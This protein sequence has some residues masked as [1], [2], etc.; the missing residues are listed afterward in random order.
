MNKKFT[1]HNSGERKAFV[2]TIYHFFAL[3]IPL[4]ALLPLL[5]HAGLPNTA[6]GPAHLMRQ[7]ELNEA[8]QQ[9]TFYPRW[10]TDL[11]LGHGMP[12]FSYAP[13]SLYHGTQL[14]H[15]LGLPLDTA[16]KA[17]LIVTFLLYSLGMFLFVRR[18]YGTYPALFAAAVYV[19]APYRLREAYIQGNYGQFIGLACYP[20]IF[21]AFHGLITEERPRFFNILAPLSLAALLF[22]H[23]ISTMLFGPIFAVYLLFL[24]ALIAFKSD[25]STLVGR[26]FAP[27]LRTFIG[28]LLGL[29]LSAIFWLP[30]FGE[31]HDIK[32]EG[33][34]EGFFDFRENFIS[35]TEFTA[36]PVLLDLAAINPE[37][38]LSLGLA[39]LIT[40]LLSILALIIF[41]LRRLASRSITPATQQSTTPYTIF[42]AL[43]FLTYSFLA[44]PSSQAVWENIPLLELAE[45]PWRMLGPAIFCAAVLAGAGLAQVMSL[46]VNTNTNST[47][48]LPPPLSFGKSLPLQGEGAKTSPLVGGNEG[49][50]AIQ[51]STFSFQI[52]TLIAIT[53]VIALNAPY[54]YPSQFIVWGTPEPP[55]AF[56]YEVISGAIGTTS[57]GEFLPRGAQQHPEPSVFENDY[58]AGR[59]PEKL[60]PSTVPDTARVNHIS[61]LA[62]QDTW[63]IET[64]E[65]F[66]ATLRTLYWPGWQLYLNDDPLDFDITPNTGLIQA[67][68]PPGEHTLT[69]RL[70]STPL[71]T[72]GFWLTTISFIGLVG[73]LISILILTKSPNASTTASPTTQGQSL[74][75]NLQSPIIILLLCLILYAISRPLAPLFVHQSDPDQPRPADQ[76]MAIDFGDQIRLVGVDNLPKAV[77]LS[78][79]GAETDLEAVLYWRAIQDLETNYSV[80]LHLDSPNGQTYATVDEVHPD[81][82]PTRN[83]PPGLYLRNPLKLHIP[84]DIPPIRYDLTVGVYDRATNERLSLA[85]GQTVANIGSIWLTTPNEPNITNPVARFGPS[86]MLAQPVLSAETLQL[87]WQTSQPL[88]PNHTIFVHLLDSE[89]NLIDQRDGAPFDNQYLLGDWL[90]NTPILDQRNISANP[91]LAAIAIGIYHTGTGERLPVTNTEGQPQPDNSFVWVV[92]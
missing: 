81:N 41:L 36:P 19:Y 85:D 65:E 61:H 33:I 67:T 86:V 79:S 42:F 34:T 68:I 40:A 63:Q 58:E 25:K 87:R 3:I 7:V 60:D 84:A 30:A 59:W 37:F 45:F 48:T 72:I 57:T 1:I 13:P 10:G 43:A 76:G 31:R 17:I 62:E 50:R 20:L 55:D 8:W 15:L 77:A 66:Q 4:F 51:T 49:G 53:I 74:I 89:N 22:S 91:E 78:P 35:L 32:L 16:M 26:L 71:R 6:D 12:I 44:L 88:D 56:T 21:W 28:G 46:W 9:G 11:A 39:Q 14:F 47:N 18:I 24:L 80:F 70:E 82:I 75:S 52:L 64:P 2:F 23:N 90:P 54:L 69:L 38:P 83:W 5:T 92:E 27:T 29:G 73:G